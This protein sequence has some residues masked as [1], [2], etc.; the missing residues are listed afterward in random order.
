M[1][2]VTRTEQH[3]ASATFGRRVTGRDLIAVASAFV[4]GLLLFGVILYLLLGPL[5]QGWALS[6]APVLA[7]PVLG[8]P[9]LWALL[10]R[11]WA[12]ADLGFVRGRRLGHLLWEVP[13][14]WVAALALTVTLGSLL[15]LSPAGDSGD[16]AAAAYL[17]GGLL[18]LSALLTV[19][20]IP[21]LEEVCFRRVLFGWAQ[22]RAGSVVAIVASAAVF[23][24][25]HIVPAAMVLQF[26]IGLG[27]GVLVWRHQTLWASLALHAL[28]N[29]IVVAIV[30]AA[31]V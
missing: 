10:G 27:T 9:I 8:A 12:W 20:V 30:G 7:T 31:L 1:G 26:F 28:N 21:A 23:G 29:G 15:G 22:Q 6:F 18:F 13:L 5:D 17:G 19:V 3:P 4:L 14:A 2:P 11:G 25:I 24:L 16:T